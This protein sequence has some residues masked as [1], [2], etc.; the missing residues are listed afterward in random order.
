[1]GCRCG[2]PNIDISHYVPP[3]QFPNQQKIRDMGLKLPQIPQQP[4]P[5][6]RYDKDGFCKTCGWLLKKIKV[7]DPRTGVTAERYVCTNARCNRRE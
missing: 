6:T 5:A 3:L 1:M 7:H 2:K 4:L